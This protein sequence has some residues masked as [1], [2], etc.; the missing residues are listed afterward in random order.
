MSSRGLRFHEPR[1]PIASEG[2]I[3]RHEASTRRAHLLIDNGG[4]IMTMSDR[5]IIGLARPLSC[6]RNREN[7]QY[8]GV[9][10]RGRCA[11]QRNREAETSSGSR[12][13]SPS[14]GSRGINM[15]SM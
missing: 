3:G 10:A 9:M 8:F 13:K 11:R 12:K 15:A 14:N 2:S 4:R 6:R 1:H 5:Q 7:F